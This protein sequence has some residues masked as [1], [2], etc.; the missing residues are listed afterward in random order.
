MIWRSARRPRPGR[1]RRRSRDAVPCPLRPSG[2]RPDP[3]PAA[4][5][6]RPPTPC[7][8]R[9]SRPTC[10]GAGSAATTTRSAGSGAWRSTGCAT[11]TVGAPQG[12]HCR[13]ADGQR[14]ARSPSEPPSPTSRRERPGHAGLPRQQRLALALFYVDGMSRRRGRRGHAPERGR[15]E[16]PPPRRRGPSCATRCGPRMVSADV[17][18]ESRSRTPIASRART[19][20]SRS[21]R[22]SWLTAASAGERRVPRR[23][24]GVHRRDRRRR[25]AAAPASRGGLSRRDRGGARVRPRSSALAAA[26]GAEPPLSCDVGPRRPLDRGRRRAPSTARP[27][28]LIVDVTTSSTHDSTVDDHDRPRRRPRRSSTDGAGRPHRPPSTPRPAGTEPADDRAPATTAPSVDDDDAGTRR[29]PRRRPALRPHRHRRRRRVAPAVRTFS[30]DGGVDRRPARRGLA[31][32]R[33]AP[34]RRRYTRR[35]ARRHAAS[36]IEVR[37]VLGG[38]DDD[39]GRA[40]RRPMIPASPKRRDSPPPRR[41]APPPTSTVAATATA[42]TAAGARQPRAALGH[43]APDG[44]AP[45]PPAPADPRDG[46][47]TA[48]PADDR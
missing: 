30:G 28:S 26:D 23:Q 3:R 45:A 39:P 37:F 40:A 48:R 46:G 15:G 4:A 31:A 11:T 36:A 34:C 32:R 9:S 44:R 10:T 22:R 12:P 38:T 35:R 1:A 14:D 42:S 19:C 33:H 13:A 25:R 16:V 7:R 5:A 27:S 43:R 8:R 17:A 2:A 41:H 29:R 24:R 20:A 21:A 47:P 6:R 18:S